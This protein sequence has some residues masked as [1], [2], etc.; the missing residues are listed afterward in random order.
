MF[1]WIIEQCSRSLTILEHSPHPAVFASSFY[2]QIFIQ[3]NNISPNELLLAQLMQLGSILAAMRN[4]L[5][6]NPN[7]TL[8]HAIDSYVDT[9]FNFHF[10]QVKLI[11]LLTQHLK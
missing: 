9:L 4:A 3:G 1:C 2:R 8:L 10:S 11:A 6:K 5:K 7:Q